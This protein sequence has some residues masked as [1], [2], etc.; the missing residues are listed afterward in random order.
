M[1]LEGL[2]LTLIATH[3]KAIAF[4]LIAIT[5]TERR[6]VPWQLCLKV[7]ASCFWRMAP[8]KYSQAAITRLSQSNLV[9]ALD[10]WCVEWS[11]DE[12]ELELRAKL[13]RAIWKPKAKAAPS[14]GSGS[15]D[16]RTMRFKV[17][18]ES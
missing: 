4:R 2:T 9:E 17:S 11:S 8:K 16:S 5:I 6:V 14:P 13:A 1:L 18:V 10:E 3:L 12:L 7:L 15:E